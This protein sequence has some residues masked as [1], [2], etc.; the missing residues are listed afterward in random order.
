MAD[1]MVAL[2]YHL[3]SRGLVVLVDTGI[4]VSDLPKD[5]E[6]RPVEQLATDADL[7]VAIGGDGTML[8]AAQLAIGRDI[9]L[10]GINR[11]RLGFLTDVSPDDMIDPLFRLETSKD[12]ASNTMIAAGTPIRARITPSVLFLER[13]AVACES[14]MAPPCRLHA[15]ASGAVE[16]RASGTERIARS[17]GP[18]LGTRGGVDMSHTSRP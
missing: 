8:F 10:L 3:R 9:P 17:I 4:T 5:V 6:R 15:R 11:G 12:A 7:I 13:V 14:L 1:S 18:Y 2:A 16:I